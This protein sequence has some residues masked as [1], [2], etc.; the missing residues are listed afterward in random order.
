[1]PSYGS[2]CYN[3][4]FPLIVP[5]EGQ[6]QWRT[7]VKT[8]PYP[9]ISQK[10]ESVTVPHDPPP[11]WCGAFPKRVPS[12]SC[13]TGDE[14][15]GGSDPH[16]LVRWCGTEGGNVFIVIFTVTPLGGRSIHS[17]PCGKADMPKTWS[18]VVLVNLALTAVGLRLWLD[19]WTAR[20]EVPHSV[21]RGAG[22]LR[23]CRTGFSQRNH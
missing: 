10:R 15:D 23:P 7:R 3:A 1:M 17:D 20:G 16:L 22:A 18:H 11:L 6:C 8:L 21:G 19:P 9:T 14:K 4:H 12:H 2:T 13:A 5:S